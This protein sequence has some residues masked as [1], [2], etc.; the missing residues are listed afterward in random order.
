LILLCSIF[1]PKIFTETMQEAAKKLAPRYKVNSIN[2]E[3]LYYL[4]LHL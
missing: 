1:V 4:P 3:Y 2:I